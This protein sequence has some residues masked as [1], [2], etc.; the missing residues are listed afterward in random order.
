MD[1]QQYT[2]YVNSH[3]EEITAHV[4]VCFKKDRVQIKSELPNAQGYGV[5]Q[6]NIT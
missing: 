5:L 2:N 4:G 1:I 6:L 3:V